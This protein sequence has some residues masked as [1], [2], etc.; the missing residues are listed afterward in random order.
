[1]VF[2]LFD[3]NVRLKIFSDKITFLLGP[4]TAERKQLKRIVRV[5]DHLKLPCPMSGSQPMSFDWTKDSE[6][7]KTYAWPRQVDLLNFTYSFQY[8]LTFYDIQ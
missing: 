7:I 3:R 2:R 1:M 4:P 6:Q 8:I 5:G